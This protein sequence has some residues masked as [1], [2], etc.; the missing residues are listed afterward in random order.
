MINFKV[1]HSH[2]IV[3]LWTLVVFSDGRLVFA[4]NVCTVQ[5]LIVTS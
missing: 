2:L 3:V 4:L 5:Y 1:F